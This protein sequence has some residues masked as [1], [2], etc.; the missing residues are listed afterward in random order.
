MENTTT[1]PMTTTAPPETDTPKKDNT[2]KILII[3]AGCGC[4]L[5]VLIVAGILLLGGGTLVGINSAQNAARDAE[6]IAGGQDFGVNLADFYSQNSTYPGSIAFQDKGVILRLK[7]SSDDSAKVD[8]YLAFNLTGPAWTG[9]NE[10]ILYTDM[11]KHIFGKTTETTTAWCFQ[12]QDD[13]YSLGLKLE[14]GT[15]KQL[16]TSL[17]SCTF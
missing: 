10:T 5:L 13:G 1:A 14:N 6:R 8:K 3:V 12:W 16:G 4:L 11:Q 17:T 2:K 7:T 9:S 15:T